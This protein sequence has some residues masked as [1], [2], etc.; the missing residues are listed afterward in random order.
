VTRLLGELAGELREGAWRPLPARR[1]LIPKP[2]SSEQEAT[3]E[4]NPIKAPYK[5][6]PRAMSEGSQVGAPEA[7]PTEPVTWLRD[8]EADPAPV[9]FKGPRLVCFQAREAFEKARTYAPVL[10]LGQRAGLGPYPFRPCVWLDVPYGCR[11]LVDAG[12]ACRR[13][14]RHYS[15]MGNLA[16]RLAATTATMLDCR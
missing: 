16:A 10:P 14:G 12:N 1:V 8:E 11:H 5:P 3:S 13:R 4:A 6:A 9:P 7:K 15:V 2:G